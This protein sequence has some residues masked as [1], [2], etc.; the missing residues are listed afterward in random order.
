MKKNNSHDDRPSLVTNTPGTKLLAES[1]LFHHD[2]N[3]QIL[4]SIE[5]AEILSDMNIL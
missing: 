2:V 4:V 3:S 5:N 1:Y